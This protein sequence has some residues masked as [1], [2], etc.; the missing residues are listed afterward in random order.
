MNWSAYIKSFA[1]RSSASVSRT[2]RITKKKYDVKRW[3]AMVNEW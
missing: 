2:P 3:V 1:Y